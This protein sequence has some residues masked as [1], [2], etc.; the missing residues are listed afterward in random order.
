MPSTI[1]ESNKFNVSLVHRQTIPHLEEDH[2][3][4][5][6][7]LSAGMFGINENYHET[8]KQKNKSKTKK[9]APLF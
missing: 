4:I 1:E 3:V 9:T 2:F 7:V 6:S 8:V 5:E